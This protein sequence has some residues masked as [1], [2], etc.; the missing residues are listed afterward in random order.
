M[1]ENGSGNMLINEDTTYLM[2]VTRSKS[3]IAKSITGLENAE[4]GGAFF[5]SRD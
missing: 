3:E 2:V 4:M 5:Y 1:L